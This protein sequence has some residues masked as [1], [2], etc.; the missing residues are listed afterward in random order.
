MKKVT[1]SLLLLIPFCLFAQD[2]SY[3]PCQETNDEFE[4]VF[5]FVASSNTQVS[6]I[7]SEP[8]NTIYVPQ[9][10]LEEEPVLLV[11]PPPVEE[12]VEEE[13]EPDMDSEETSTEAKAKSQSSRSKMKKSKKRFKRKIKKRKK[14]RKYKGKCPFF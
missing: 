10:I 4:D 2:D 14:A 11:L 9:I 6:I 1:I 7:S 5:N 12:E 3:C 13:E 8:T